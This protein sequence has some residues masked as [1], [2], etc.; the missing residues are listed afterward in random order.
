MSL[1][2]LNPSVSATPANLNDQ[3]AYAKYLAD[4]G[5][6]PDAFKRRPADILIALAIADDLGESAW[7]VMSEMSVIGGKPS[8]SAKFMRARVRKAGHKLR[9]SF[10]AG[11]AR[12]VIVRN[13]DPEFEHVAIWDEHKAKAHGLW[14]KGHWT[15]NPDLMLANRALSECVREACYEVMG[16]VGYT[17]DEVADFTPKTNGYA[18]AE[19][20]SVT[21]VPHPATSIAEAVAIEAATPEQAKPEAF[22]EVESV[23]VSK[24]QL[25]TLAQEMKRLGLDK[26]EMLTLA[27]EVTGRTIKTSAELSTEEADAV[28]ANLTH[29]NVPDADGVVDALVV[30]PWGEQ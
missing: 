1:Q 26:A 14:G 3:I 7:T 30:D 28:I 10:E 12:C 13:D 11:K 20:V 19:T 17:P 6:L 24:A 15:K 4:A 21:Q 5:L 8:F 27:A 2:P 25:A 23:K 16:G 29:F 22:V 18:S 9:E